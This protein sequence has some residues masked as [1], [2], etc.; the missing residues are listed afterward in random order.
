MKIE[1]AD[2][3]LSGALGE[4]QLDDAQNEI[5]EIKESDYQEPWLKH[6]SDE[7][8]PEFRK[9]GKQRVS[10]VELNNFSLGRM[11]FLMLCLCVPILGWAWLY[12]RFTTIH[13]GELV[14]VI[15]R[16]G[17]T[18]V[19]HS[20]MGDWFLMDAIY[21]WEQVNSIRLQGLSSGA[22]IK[23]MGDLSVIN[24]A[25]SHVLP[26]TNG[27]EH[28]FCSSG[29]H[30]YQWPQP[31]KPMINS[32]LNKDIAINTSAA[33]AYWHAQNTGIVYV[34]TLPGE[35]ILVSDSERVF[36]LKGSGL[37]D[38]KGKRLLGLSPAQNKLLSMPTQKVAYTC[39][40]LGGWVST[41]DMSFRLEDPIKLVNLMPLGASEDEESLIQGERGRHSSEQ[42]HILTRAGIDKFIQE[43][44]QINMKTYLAEQ[45]SFLPVVLAEEGLSEEGSAQA[46]QLQYQPVTSNVQEAV[47]QRLSEA[48][49]EIGVVLDSLSSFKTEPESGNI[50]AKSILDQY[51]FQ[52]D[53][54]SQAQ[55]Q[56]TESQQALR[57]QGLDNKLQL[58]QQQSDAE[59]ARLNQALESELKLAN[60]QLE[61]ELSQSRNQL[62]REQQAAINDL[63]LKQQQAL[64][65]LQVHLQVST[66]TELLNAVSSQFKSADEQSRVID[67]LYRPE[68]MKGALELMIKSG[69]YP[70][71]SSLA[72][73]REF[74]GPGSGCV[75]IGIQVKEDDVSMRGS[76][77]SPS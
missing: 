51:T 22:E 66:K 36:E 69:L 1:N 53:A 39:P 75:P 33:K 21:P 5:I 52:I 44:V 57:Q 10:E 15:D 41:I 11:L 59:Q 16:S 70:P 74:W 14:G 54:Q 46:P 45:S 31:P 55:K 76:V 40:Q 65:E 29:V 60:Q 17:R 23:T 27:D 77:Q 30:L 62:E 2:H 7:G 6:F 13:V 4:S 72:A 20:G 38:L 49:R 61:N 32:A 28:I 43:R 34:N 42:N 12:H 37:F 25:N 9:E 3:C 73:S 71:N 26:M 50:V 47:S 8:L 48:L 19:I 58:A 35:R 63:E 24:V 64:N 56:Q 18:R 67:A 68:S